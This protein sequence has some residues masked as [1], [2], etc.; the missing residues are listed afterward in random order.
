MGQLYGFEC[1]SCGYHTEVS[2][3][4]DRG[5]VAF[6]QTKVCQDCKQVV[7]ILIGKA[8]ELSAAKEITIPKAKQQCPDCK[9]NNLKVWKG[10]TCPK[11]GAKMNKGGGA[12]CMWD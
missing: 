10:R 7:D 4:K 9:S 2:G 3:G 5:F 1:P 8:A 6:T 12:I 11:C